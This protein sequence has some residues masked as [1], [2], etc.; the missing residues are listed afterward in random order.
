[1]ILQPGQYRSNRSNPSGRPPKRKREIRPMIR[2]TDCPYADDIR[3]AMQAYLPMWP[4]EWGPAQL[5]Q[6]SL[7]KPDA[8]SEAGAMG[9]AQFMPETWLEMVDVMGYVD[10]ASPYD[11]NFA[12]PA[13]AKYMQ[14]LRS[15]WVKVQRPEDDRRRI[16][17]A[18]Y[19]C[20]TGNM[21]HAQ[22]LANGA[23]NYE[24]I[25]AA[26][27]QVTGL[28]NAHQTSDYVVKIARWYGELTTAA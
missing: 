23:S 24:A 3:R 28:A 27:P 16:T 8:K 7:W 12:I 2:L 6:E 4:W 25:I 9:I 18:C 11:P 13:F 14:R 5:Y 21:L 17:Q 15:N 26:L 1:M 10:T 19:N 20:G 22:R